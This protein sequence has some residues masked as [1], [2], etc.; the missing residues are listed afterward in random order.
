MSSQAF[1]SALMMQVEMSSGVVGPTAAL[2]ALQA[3]IRLSGIPINYMVRML[4]IKQ[5]GTYLKA[6][7]FNKYIYNDFKTD[8]KRY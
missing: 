4:N 8:V 5:D 7:W 3:G 1:L 2:C 6:A